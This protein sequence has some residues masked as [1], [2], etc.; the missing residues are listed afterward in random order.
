MDSTLKAA[1]GDSPNMEVFA[2]MPDTT[3]LGS[4]YPSELE[5]KY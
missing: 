1:S 3:T 5:Y 4:D 2:S